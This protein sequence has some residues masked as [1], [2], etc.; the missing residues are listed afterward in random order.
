MFVKLT[1]MVIYRQA[2]GGVSGITW[3][4]QTYDTSTA[5]VSGSP[6][7]ETRTVAQGVDIQE[8]EAVLVQFL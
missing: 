5:L 4:N 3:G 6:S 8:T 1:L 2:T 7:V